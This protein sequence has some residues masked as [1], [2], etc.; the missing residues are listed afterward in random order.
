MAKINGKDIPKAEKDKILKTQAI[1]HAESFYNYN[2]IARATGITED[3]LKNW[4]DAD[5]DFSGELEQSRTRFLNRRIK[6]AK[7][8][9]LLERLEPEIFKQRTETKTEVTLPT[10][11]MDI[12]AILTD[13]SNNKDSQA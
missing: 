3:T 9:F 12:N 11:I 13:N 1:I 10:P 8:E 6:Q 5:L 2:L 7:P 4:R